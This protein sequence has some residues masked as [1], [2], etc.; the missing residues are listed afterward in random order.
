MCT[1][2]TLNSDDFLVGRNMD[3]EYS[4]GEALVITPRDYDWKWRKEKSDGQYFAMMGVATVQDNYPLYA[5]AINEHGL[6]MASLNFPGNAK[7]HP[8]DEEKVNLTPF[9]FIP[10]I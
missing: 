6:A 4:F 10:Y 5:E 9:E 1:F 7:Y 3:I 2:I 8:Y